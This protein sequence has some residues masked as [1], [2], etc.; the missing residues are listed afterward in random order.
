MALIVF[1]SLC[2]IYAKIYF[3]FIKFSDAK[4]QKICKLIKVSFIIL[5]LQITTGISTVL[6]SIPIAT[7]LVHSAG[8]TLL[9]GSLLY[10]Y[11]QLHYY[12]KS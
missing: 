9:I 8:A 2:L 12:N 3:N 7:G 10:I 5:L 11:W 4:S 1:I 6:L